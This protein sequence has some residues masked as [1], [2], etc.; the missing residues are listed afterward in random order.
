MG[1]STTHLVLIFSV[2]LFV[3]LLLFMFIFF[4][5]QA[6]AIGG[7]FGSVVNAILPIS[8]GLIIGKKKDVNEQ[9]E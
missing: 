9:A 6:F 8:A 1:L 5:V 7:T 2:L 4:G 3:L